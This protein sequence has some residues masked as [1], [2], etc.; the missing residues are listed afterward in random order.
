[1]PKAVCEDRFPWLMNTSIPKPWQVPVQDTAFPFATN[2]VAMFYGL[3]LLDKVKAMVSLAGIFL[4]PG[5]GKKK[6][7]SS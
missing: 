5:G 3:S 6:A 1:M 4:L 7:K 2:M